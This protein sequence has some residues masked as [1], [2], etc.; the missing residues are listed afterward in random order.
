MKPNSI[1]YL[2]EKEKRGKGRERI[3][4]GGGGWRGRGERMRLGW[5][6]DFLGLDSITLPVSYKKEGKIMQSKYGC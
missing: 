2:R 3:K 5:I 6:L 1:H 4:G